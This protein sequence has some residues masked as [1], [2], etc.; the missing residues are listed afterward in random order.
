MNAKDKE[1]LDEVQAVHARME[2]LKKAAAQAHGKVAT[3]ERAIDR[4]KE[5]YEKAKEEAKAADREVA[6]YAAEQRKALTKMMSI[7]AKN[8]ELGQEMLGKALSMATDKAS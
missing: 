8:P 7:L 4:A 5:R 3:Q 2:E 1:A 6:G